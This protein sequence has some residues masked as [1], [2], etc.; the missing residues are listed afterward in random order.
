M[1]KHKK[2]R[3]AEKCRLVTDVRNEVWLPDPATLKLDGFSASIKSME[4]Y[5]LKLF[6]SPSL[7]L[8]NHELFRLVPT[9][10]SFEYREK[11]KTEVKMALV[12]DTLSSILFSRHQI[13]IAKT[14]HSI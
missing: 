9:D 11:S 12:Y 7:W 8:C 2:A 3:L 5:V 14:N 13:Y 1:Q 4:P 10:E 6:I